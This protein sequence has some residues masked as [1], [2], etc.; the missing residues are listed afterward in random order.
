MYLGLERAAAELGPSHPLHLIEAGQHTTDWIRDGLAE[1]RQAL[2]PGVRHHHLDGRDDAAMADARHAAD[3][4]CSLSD[5]IQETFGLT[6]VEAMAAGLPVV[7][8]DWDGYRDT[9]VQ[10]ETALLVPT[11]LPATGAGVSIARRYEDGLDNHDHYCA[12]ASLAT[13]VDVPAAALALTALLGQPERRLAM[14]E[15]GRRRARALYDW[16]VVIGRYQELW[17]ELAA[18]RGAGAAPSP[19]GSTPPVSP[20]PAGGGAVNPLR[21]NPF[22]LFGHCATRHLRP[23]SRLRA[24]ADPP[25]SLAQLAGLRICRLDGRSPH[26]SAATAALLERLR[27][28]GE[29]GLAQAE[30]LAALP[31]AERAPAALGLG[32]LLKAGLAAIVAL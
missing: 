1:A 32:W 11:T 16:G 9:L 23:S 30:L 28:A 18:I 4:F 24:A 7:A 3:V 20:S 14:G 25:A 6:P 19:A 22:L 10:G 8:S 15:A 12:Q 13:A 21:D 2:M 26:P 17:A 31:E 5:N 27:R 29:A